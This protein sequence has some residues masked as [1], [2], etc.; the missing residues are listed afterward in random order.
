MADACEGWLYKKARTA[1][2][3]TWQ[4][5]YF[6]LDPGSTLLSYLKKQDDRKDKGTVDLAQL[7]RVFPVPQDDLGSGSVPRLRGPFGFSLQLEERTYHL[8]PESAAER[9]DWL[10]AVA[11]QFGADLRT[12]ALQFAA[13]PDVA[14][15]LI[16]GAR[17]VISPRPTNETR[18]GHATSAVTTVASG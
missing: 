8:L 3:A 2:F 5:R 18:N 16:V 1:G 13:A 11:A 15:A 9:D 10:R 6:R 4:R 7:R 14:A 17:P 12:A